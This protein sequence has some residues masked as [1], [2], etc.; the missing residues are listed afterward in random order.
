MMRVNEEME[1]EFSKFTN[2]YRHCLHDHTCMLAKGDRSKNPYHEVIRRNHKEGDMKN[3]GDHQDT[4]DSEVAQQPTDDDSYPAGLTV[5][6]KDTSGMKLASVT[7]H[8]G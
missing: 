8:E 2:E 5:K 6:L 7:S 4:G 1:N 3:E